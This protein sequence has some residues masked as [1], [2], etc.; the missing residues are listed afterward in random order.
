M[1]G[2]F[3]YHKGIFHAG[4]PTLQRVVVAAQRDAFRGGSDDTAIT[5]AE[6]FQRR[7][8]GGFRIAVTAAARKQTQHH[9]SA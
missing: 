1:R 8:A 3:L 2:V 9:G 4:G 7:A 5:D 6:S